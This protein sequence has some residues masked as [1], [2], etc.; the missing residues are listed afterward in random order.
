M[1]NLLMTFLLLAN[2]SF[3]SDWKQELEQELPLM[4]HRNWV[5]VADSAYPLQTSPGIKTLYA[6]GD[7]V[8]VLS[9][10]LEAVSDQKHV[11][12]VIFT[13]AE[14]QHVDESHAPGIG[15]FRKQLASALAQRDVE[16]LP[17]D[18]IIHQLD[19]AGG[20]FRVMIIKTDLAL[21]YTSVFIRLDCG[22]WSADAEEALREA[23]P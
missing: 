13:D 8:A 5:V 12:P 4:G 21:P 10:V 1:K 22:Y 9:Q 19:E 7:H 2:L 3:A 17:H 15:A 18:A 20:A 11:R 6:G 23:M 14:L 16:V